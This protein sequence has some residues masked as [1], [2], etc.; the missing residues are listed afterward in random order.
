[1]ETSLRD[2]VCIGFE[3]LAPV[4]FEGRRGGKPKSVAAS[5]SVDVAIPM[6]ASADAPVV[7]ATIPVEYRHSKSDAP[8][9][10]LLH[11]G[12]F[13][14]SAAWNRFGDG[15]RIGEDDLRA[16]ALSPDRTAGLLSLDGVPWAGAGPRGEVPADA[17]LLE[18]GRE[19]V[20]G[21]VRGALSRSL[22]FVDGVLHRRVPCPSISV[23]DHRSGSWSIDVP[24]WLS[25]RTEGY[26]FAAD[27]LDA[28]HAFMK[29]NQ[30]PGGVKSVSCRFSEVIHSGPEVL[31]FD[32]GPRNAR[33]A[34]ATALYAVHEILPKLP[35]API[36]ALAELARIRDGLDGGS[37]T[38]ADADAALARLDAL[39]P[40]M[41]TTTHLMHAIRI[42][43]DAIAR[44]LPERR[45]GPV[46]LDADDLAALGSLATA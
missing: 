12:E 28:L 30:R 20:A 43:R 9:V 19:A 44:S 40:L 36:L 33:Y 3:C 16:D 2:T 10:R 13:W 26:A 15:P 46:S 6:V 35:E 25:D 32:E 4:T 11:R 22:L 34:I 21:A 42:G 17:R 1:M 18:D 29:A 14:Q 38:A 37:T 8:I 31:G 27:R 23:C 41:G 5:L 39:R 7:F 45:G 24:N